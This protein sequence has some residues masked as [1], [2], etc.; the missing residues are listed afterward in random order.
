MIMAISSSTRCIFSNTPSLFIGILSS[1][2]LL[3]QIISNSHNFHHSSS[4]SKIAFVFHLEAGWCLQFCS[5]S[6]QYLGG[7]NDDTHAYFTAFRGRL[8]NSLALLWRCRPP[9]TPLN[10]SVLQLKADF[11][12]FLAC[13][14]VASIVLI[15]IYCYKWMHHSKDDCVYS[16]RTIRKCTTCFYEKIVIVGIFWFTHLLLNCNNSVIENGAG[17][18][19]RPFC[20]G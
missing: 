4:L 8:D 15:W 6:L 11:F 7:L 5:G 16:L 20:H 19:Q 14:I 9:K 17:I 10:S 18:A 3:P 12:V 13:S 1:I 2:Q